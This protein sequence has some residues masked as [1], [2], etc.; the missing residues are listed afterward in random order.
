[1]ATD[2]QVTPGDELERQLFRALEEADNAPLPGAR[3]LPILHGLKPKGGFTQPQENILLR[4]TEILMESG[5]IY[6]YGDTLVMQTDRRDDIPGVLTPL[7]TGS[8]VEV[9]ANDLLANVFICHQG[10]SQFSVPIWFAKLLLRSELLIARLPR[11]RHYAT[12]PLF[13]HDFI[14]R[15]PGWHPDVGILINGPESE[16]TIASPTGGGGPAMDRLPPHLRTLLRGF[17]FRNDADVAN[18]IG[19]MLT[20]LLINHFVLAGKPIALVDGNQPGLGKTLLIR[21]IGVVLDNLDPCLLHFTQDDEE[22][23]KRICATLQNS[24]QSVLLIDN[25]KVRSGRVVTSPTIEANSMAPQVTLRILGKSENFTRPNDVL[26]ALTMN[27]TRISPDLVSRGLP[28]QLAYEGKPEDRTFE[29]PDPIS[30]AREHRQHILGEL[31]GIV[32]RWNQLG[33]PLGQ[34]SHRLHQWA[35]RIGG[36][37]ELA[38]LPEFLA[39]AGTAAAS[40]NMELDELAALAEAVINNEGPYIEVDQSGGD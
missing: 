5:R 10:E 3:T 2:R 13:D 26:W 37:L 16:P 38:G 12:R 27:D 39:N 6:A 30:Y 31:A 32:I 23:Q 33:R 35:A 24:R 40:F 14:L 36:M 19:I 34:C 17:C 25:A 21:T 4:A 18:T 9:G 28:I 20:G 15:G 22:L 29:G 1:L 8:I 7:R 11:I